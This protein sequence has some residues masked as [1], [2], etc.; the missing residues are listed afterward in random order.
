[1]G[2]DSVLVADLNL[3]RLTVFAGGLVLGSLRDEMDVQSVV[4][5][6]LVESGS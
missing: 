3:G 2:R 1:M 4:V 5:Y 6:E